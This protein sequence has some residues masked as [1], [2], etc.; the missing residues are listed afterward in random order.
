[1]NRLIYSRIWIFHFLSMFI[2]GCILTASAQTNTAELHGVLSDPSGNRVPGAAINVQTLDTGLVRTFTTGDDGSYAFL[3]LRPGQYSVRI[4]AAGFRPVLAKGIT[5]TVGQKAELS[6][7]LEI[8]PVM[9]AVEILSNTQLLEA[10]RT[11]VA[12]TIVERLIKSLP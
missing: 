4:S 8:S 3:G 10:R 7:R 9:E 5:L 1:M 11:S 2:P 6:S 12:T